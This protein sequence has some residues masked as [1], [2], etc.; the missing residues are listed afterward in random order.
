MILAA[1]MLCSQVAASDIPSGDLIPSD[2]TS[3]AA[4]IDVFSDGTDISS[5]S[6]TEDFTSG[7]TDESGLFSDASEPAVLVPDEDMITPPSVTA[8][9][10]AA[11]VE[12][13][14]N[15]Y[16]LHIEWNIQNA[17]DQT[18]SL[19]LGMDSITYAAL[20]EAMMADSEGIC[21]VPAAD[22]SGLPMMLSTDPQN[23]DRVLLT[24][25][26]T[27]DGQISADFTVSAGN[28]ETDSVSTI[29]AEWYDANAAAWTTAGQADLNWAAAAVS[30]EVSFEE[31]NTE[32]MDE[33]PTEEPEQIEE[34]GVEE[35][36]TPVEE[37]AVTDEPTSTEE[38]VPT[39]GITPTENPE[40]VEE[41]EETEK[42][43]PAEEPATTE[44][45]TPIEEAV[46]TEEIT[47][48]EE[49]TPTE[50]AS[51]DAE[52]ESYQAEPAEEAESQNGSE[53][54][55]EKINEE[56]TEAE[57]VV[58][59]PTEGESKSE[60][61]EDI[62]DTKD[63]EDMIPLGFSDS[64]MMFAAP[65]EQVSFLN[66]ITR[67]E[68]YQ[69]VNNTWVKVQDGN[70][71]DENAGDL[72]N[73]VKASIEYTL[74][75]GT[76]H[77]GEEYTISDRSI[78][79][80]LSDLHMYSTAN[81][82]GTVYED[83]TAVGSYSINAETGEVVIIFDPDFAKENDDGPVY[84]TLRF[85]SKWETN[86]I[87]DDSSIT[88]T[89]GDQTTIIIWPDGVPGDVTAQ[90]SLSSYDYNTG[91]VTYKLTVA[92]QK[93]T[94][95]AVQLKDTLTGFVSAE[96]MN[97]ISVAKNNVPLTP[98]NAGS[99]GY[100]VSGSTA[101]GVTVTLPRMSAG[102]TYEV[103]VTAKV[104]AD[105][106]FDEYITID[107]NLVASSTNKKN[108]DIS[109]TG[110]LG[111]TINNSMFNKSGH[112]DKD[113]NGNP[114]IRWTIVVNSNQADLTGMT[115][116]DSMLSQAQDMKITP[117]NGGYAHTAQSNTI[118]FN[119]LE[120]G[121]NTTEYTI[122][123]YTYVTEGAKVGENFS[124]TNT[125]ELKRADGSSQKKDVTVSYN[126]KW[127][128]KTGT[129]DASNSKIEWTIIINE[130]GQDIVGAVLTDTMFSK[131]D[132][133]G[134]TVSNTEGTPAAGY[135]I[136][137]DTN[138]KVEKIT[139]G[140]IDNSG[141]NRNTYIVR[142]KTSVSDAD[143][144][145]N[146]ATVVNEG[147][148]E[149]PD[150]G[151]AG[152]GSIG[153]NVSEPNLNKTGEYDSSNK[154][155]NWTV[156]LN[157][158]F[159][160][161]TG[162]VFHDT[163]DEA[164]NGGL[165]TGGKIKIYDASNPWWCF[166]EIRVA[167]DNSKASGQYDVT[168]YWNDLAETVA[169]SDIQGLVNYV[170]SFW[171]DSRY[172]ECKFEINYSTDVKVIGTET[173]TN[174]AQLGNK[175][176]EWS[177]TVDVKPDKK[178]ENV[179]SVTSEE[180]S[181]DA[182]LADCELSEIRRISWSAKLPI[183]SGG[184]PVGTA[185]Y[186]YPD[187]GQWFSVAEL[188]ANASGLTS[189]M[190][191]G[192]GESA[193]TL[194]QG[195]DYTLYLTSNASADSSSL[196]WITWDE[197]KKT[198][199]TR[200]NGFKL[201]LNQGIDGAYSAHT[202]NF[203][204]TTLVDLSSENTMK[205]AGGNVSISNEIGIVDV[206]NGGKDSDSTVIESAFS[207]N[208]TG[209]VDSA[210]AAQSN[211][212]K[213]K[214]DFEVA[215]AMQGKEVTI[216]D[217]LPEG[218]SITSKDTI[219]FEFKGLQQSALMSWKEAEEGALSGNAVLLGESGNF[220]QFNAKYKDGKITVTLDADTSVN[221]PVGDRCSIEY[222]ASDIADTLFENAEDDKVSITNKATLTYDGSSKEVSNTKDI[223]KVETLSD[224]VKKEA[225]LSGVV[226][227]DRTYIPYR[228][229]INQ[230][231]NDLIPGKDVVSMRDTLYYP[232]WDTKWN[233]A[234]ELD[235]QSVKLYYGEMD[236][237]SVIKK[238]EVPNS[239][240]GFITSTD[241]KKEAPSHF[242]DLELPDETFLILEYTYAIRV[243]ALQATSETDTPSLEISNK[244]ELYGV[245]GGNNS[246][247]DKKSYEIHESS[248]TA[249]TNN[250]T[251]YKIREGAMN[252][253]LSGAEFEL[254]KWDNS[255]WTKISQAVSGSD[256]KL[257]FETG[258]SYQEGVPYYL[259]ETKAPDGYLLDAAHYHFYISDDEITF[260][261][262]TCDV[263]GEK[264]TLE[265]MPRGTKEYLENK[266]I[267]QTKV[268]VKKEWKD[269]DGNEIT[270]GAAEINVQLYQV[271]G[272]SIDNNKKVNV[273]IGSETYE[274][275]D[276]ACFELTVQN[277]NSWEVSTAALDFQLSVDNVL[278]ISQKP[279]AVSTIIQ[280]TTI[281][282]TYRIPISGDTTVTIK[283]TG[284]NAFSLNDYKIY[285][286]YQP[287]E[288]TVEVPYGEAVV[289]SKS[290][291]WSYDWRTLPQYY[292]GENGVIYP[293]FYY[294]EEST[295]IE[296][297][298]TQYTFLN[299]LTGKIETSLS[300]PSVSVAGDYTVSNIKQEKLSVTVEK[301]WSDAAAN[302]H[303]DDSISVQLYRSTE[304]LDLTDDYT[305]EPERKITLT[306]VQYEGKTLAVQT[307]KGNRATVRVAF[308]QNGYDYVSNK[309]NL[310][311]LIS[312]DS[313][314]AIEYVKD[315]KESDNLYYL[316]FNV[317]N[318]S[319]DC[320]LEV[321]NGIYP[322]NNDISSKIEQGNYVDEDIY[323]SL[324]AVEDPVKL[325]EGQWTYSWNDLD[326]MTA[327]GQKLY[328]YVKETSSV[329]GYTALYKYGQDSA[330]RQHVTITNVKN[331]TKQITVRKEWSDPED[332]DSDRGNW[333]EMQL[334][335]SNY[336]LDPTTDF[337]E[338]PRT[339]K[340]KESA[341]SK[342]VCQESITY[343]K[344]YI[345]VAYSW[346][347]PTPESIISTTGSAVIKYVGKETLNEKHYYIYNV[348]NILEEGC[349]LIASSYPD[350]TG[351]YI[352]AGLHNNPDAVLTP[353]EGKSIRLSADNNW[354]YKWDD[355]P[356][357]DDKGEL[358]YY[359]DEVNSSV[360][361]MG[362]TKT[363]RYTT[364]G[365]NSTLVEITNTSPPKKE[366]KVKKEWADG[367][368]SHEGQSVVVQLYQSTEELSGGSGEEA[369]T[370]S[371]SISVT[372]GNEYY[373][374]PGLK[375]QSAVINNCNAVNIWLAFKVDESPG[376]NTG[377]WSCLNAD[378]KPTFSFIKVVKKGDSDYPGTD[379]INYQYAVFNVT[380]L[381]S[382]G[383]EFQYTGW[384][385]EKEGYVFPGLYNSSGSG[386]SGDEDDGLTP[387]P[388]G[389]Y[390]LNAEN[391][392]SHIWSGLPYYSGED[393]LYYYVKE[394]SVSDGSRYY[395][396]EYTYGTDEDGIPLV[397]VKNNPVENVTE[398]SVTK[399]WEGYVNENGIEAIPDYRITLQLKQNGTAHGELVTLNGGESTPWTYS[400]TNL[401]ARDSA[402]QPY[403]YTVE[404]VKVEDLG[405]DPA[406]EVTEYTAE[407]CYGVAADGKYEITIINRPETTTEHTSLSVEKKWMNTEGSDN[408]ETVSVSLY[409][410][411]DQ[412]NALSTIELG[413]SHAN[414]D[415]TG[416]DY[417]D[418]FY[419]NT[420]WKYTWSNLEVLPSD[421]SYYVVED[422]VIEGYKTTY[423]IGD[424]ASTES[425]PQ[426]VT[427]IGS[428]ETITITNTKTVDITV[429]KS[430]DGYSADEI[431]N[432]EV[433]VLLQRC[434]GS[435]YEDVSS[436]TMKIS[437][438]EELNGLLWA[439]TWSGLD[440]GYTYSVKELAVKAVAYD[441]NGN[442]TTSELVANFTT[443]YSSDEGTTWSDISANVGIQN[444]DGTVLIKNTKNR[445]GITLP[446]TG[447]KYPFVFYGLGCVFLLISAAWML[448]TFKKRNTPI[449]AGK[450]GKRSEN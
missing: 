226:N 151:T 126:V 382:G 48:T 241:G 206:Q 277:T 438:A 386:D 33:A 31:D 56:I 343:S 444:T 165:V 356:L 291:N 418:G 235:E 166:Q 1:T 246:S 392:W 117:K 155:I 210:G 190:V 350:E 169:V 247:E 45:I 393:E 298:L 297:Y 8:V 344:A 311:L 237:D 271:A 208:Y 307:I 407:Y 87:G 191:I 67:M 274:V 19:A 204:Y 295:K 15:A 355:L 59:E 347:P 26:K 186:D 440:I 289:L 253:V 394:I 337:S 288:E 144:T 281:I 57:K 90:K 118:T 397:T 34:P 375:D 329:S 254:Y 332:A 370:S 259:V 152:S 342:V 275:P 432:Y 317:K 301:K 357:E 40:Q 318:I 133:D 150:G 365:E 187:N 119:A 104:P 372:C 273:T 81:E 284:C 439:H 430:W 389:R 314:A 121:K 3:M 84:G 175:E 412:N 334:Y 369:G 115:L 63:I 236:G 383:C 349:D 232:N 276:G 58:D 23:T 242:I 28:I 68:F 193:K 50:A 156:T 105:K 72:V 85:E 401:E 338:P 95:S 396:P 173:I 262:I 29:T 14:E 240:W 302:S 398:I 200:Y 163:F 162:K 283:G 326:N 335:S 327:D 139:F 366:I 114:I 4:G 179:T 177:V 203:T 310:T 158:N 194:V 371:H 167:V 244:A 312:K 442:Q 341:N 132:A 100:E 313:N 47:P 116:T 189:Q 400:W 403:H 264:L 441:E 178:F 402:G 86:D 260:G 49:L 82:S 147:I 39:E 404:E 128:S 245:S 7:S 159:A 251:F 425:N 11:D 125:V 113:E 445:P 231:A 52:G 422:S 13:P 359:V 75:Q 378:Q 320:K 321:V 279:D 60:I 20:P 123:Y 12:N 238:E 184:I 331:P 170:N 380:G 435:K 110:N 420:G 429:K 387:V 443:Q 127:I 348:T 66:C 257:I 315:I 18:V 358:F 316:L 448:L 255:E 377:T 411:S 211:A 300:V 270:P 109:S 285:P 54:N 74:P 182:T 205:D 265:Q 168:V 145:S 89:Y 98:G 188:E 287:R 120:G 160:N 217:N 76:L 266:I 171:K 256:G 141:Q 339:V 24:Y 346:E 229:L 43:T 319:S 269:V 138:G 249:R 286:A 434:D 423:S 122:E 172:A 92:S 112:Q 79:F 272:N 258:F 41:P 345:K 252:Q 53:T 10:N 354:E 61:S 102:E 71:A 239:L 207:K 73:G 107:N 363:T 450:G 428:N 214:L 36:I 384:P 296:G 409:K 103:L 330:G 433:T 303:S 153:V 176:A 70:F 415:N 340:L 88:L 106:L 174:K 16:D 42:N 360:A 282:K 294:V 436:A 322:I 27:G 35:E 267:P 17:Q 416:S 137:P 209:S 290:N 111:H 261:D 32:N 22:G 233:Y 101:S 219:T 185:Y 180:V 134:I 390:V 77:V 65:S 222:S 263:C 364:L 140:A 94:S 55:T 2:D 408:P 130:D 328:Y 352:G 268:S 218:I 129:Y 124:Q 69:L 306:S 374:Y 215:S 225:I 96:N 353:I 136:V 449:D 304:N 308:D 333:A 44:E 224:N 395:S 62:E 195:M 385:V 299:P 37:P 413:V 373:S 305:E 292:L 368:G 336:E 426:Q 227:A 230:E 367:T 108:E 248:A 406:A 376:E 64:M 197:A 21:H 381:K 424:G 293:Y 202:I 221:L 234:A 93:G 223:V 183:S 437:D 199:S 148:L 97:V 154:T 446:G 323:Q 388:D 142:Y 196:T 399:K 280:G 324:T 220:V 212:L 91:L 80:N 431:K 201:V 181:Q 78:K 228:V 164:A 83:S 143:K 351:H 46:P 243:E 414:T 192:S 278:G 30:P 427:S 379:N 146:P 216:V 6:G 135:S 361:E 250:V 38:A 9:L 51:G 421:D 25:D 417:K 325:K 391:N 405:Q 157:D 362:Y 5:G 161:L 131:L 198:S 447:S 213:W 410:T 309:L 99:G 419:D 149:G